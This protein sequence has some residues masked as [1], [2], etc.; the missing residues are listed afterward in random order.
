MAE[1]RPRLVILDPIVAYLGAKTDAYRANEVRAIPA[2]LPRLTDR[3]GC[4]DLQPA[5]RRAG[6]R[7]AAGGRIVRAG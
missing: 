3:H 6:T 2:S 5:I 7:G 1:H 4:A